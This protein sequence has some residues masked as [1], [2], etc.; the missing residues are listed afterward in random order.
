MLRRFVLLVVLMFQSAVAFAADVRTEVFPLE[1]D[2]VKLHLERYQAEGGGG[3]KPLILVHGLTYSSREFDVNYGDYSL[4]RFLANNGFDVWLL[5]I[6]GYGQSREAGDKFTGFTPDSDYAAEDIKAAA[7][8]IVEK[9]K[10]AKLDVLGWSWG[11]VTGGRFAAKYP[12]LVN[13]LVLYAPIV[14]GLGEY[15]VP[16]EY[17]AT[18]WEHAAGD[19]QVKADKSIDYDIV[20]RPVADTFLSN[21]WLY[22][23][24]GSPNGGRRNLLV[25]PTERLIPTAKIKAPTLLIVGDQDPYVSVALCEEAL[26]TLPE[27]AKLHVLK[28]AAHAMMMEKPYYKEFRNTVLEFLAPGSAPQ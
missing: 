12:E 16:H 20:E 11:T 5:D 25:A 1:R 7:K 8:L 23:G 24:A 21:C 17:T 10:T 9:S 13:K 19:F 22:D 14:A 27:G 4:A 15:D 2:G 28:G 3:K 18:S 26:K 6:A